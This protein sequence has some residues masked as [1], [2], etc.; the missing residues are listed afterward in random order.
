[1]TIPAAWNFFF[2]G[3]GSV[4]FGSVGSAMAGREWRVEY[5][6]GEAPRLTHILVNLKWKGHSHA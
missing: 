1:M 2:F 4:E 5:F 6:T 3:A